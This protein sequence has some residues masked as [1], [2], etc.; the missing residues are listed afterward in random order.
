M[1]D[2]VWAKVRYNANCSYL[3]VD[4]SEANVDR[5]IEMTRRQGFNIFTTVRRS[6]L[7][8]LQAQAG[9]LPERLGRLATCVEKARKAGVRI[10]FHTLSNFITPNDAYVTPK[11][12]PRLA[13]IGISALTTNVDAAQTEIPVA[14]PEFFRQKTAMNGVVIGEELVRY[15]SVSTNAPWRLLGCQRGAWGTRAAAHA[16]GEPIAKLMDHDTR[17]S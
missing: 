15:T 16:G 8:A 5:A 10:G 3:I 1:L 9:P 7:G 6:R 11:P 4:F 12:D 17:S 13:R 2:G 14:S